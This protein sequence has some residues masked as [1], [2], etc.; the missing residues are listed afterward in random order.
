VE[1]PYRWLEDPDSA[2]TRVWIDAQNALTRSY[3]EPISARGTLRSRLSTLWNYERFGLPT[4]RG[5]RWFMTRN[6]GLQNQSVLY[7][8]DAEGAAPRVLLDPNAL[9]KD[10]TVALGGT[11]FSDD[12][13]YVAYGVAD[14]GS[15]WNVWR[16]RDVAGGQD[17][18]DEL[19]WVKFSGASWAH[20]NSGVSRRKAD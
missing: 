12:G 14:G 13:R 2:E 16:V 7:T 10:G 17:L 11:A 19:R 4:R 15:D 5:S 18:A 8:M 3:L 20:D 1:D 9:S 6:D